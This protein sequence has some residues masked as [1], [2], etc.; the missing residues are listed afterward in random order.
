MRSFTSHLRSQWPQ[1]CLLSLTLSATTEGLAQSPEED[2]EANEAE[3]TPALGRR[4][5]AIRNG[6]L[7][8]RTI[9]LPNDKMSAIGWLDTPN[10]S[11]FC[12]A[13]VISPT[14]IITAEHCFSDPRISSAPEVNFNLQ[15]QDQGQQ[16]KTF[17]FNQSQVMKHP[18][19]L[20]I[21]IIVFPNAPFANLPGVTPIPINRA[22][23]EGDFYD[24]LIDHQITAAGYGST[25]DRNQSGLFFASVR[26]ELI[27]SR[28]IV[29]NGERRQGI[30]PGDSG[31]PLLAPGVD[32]LVSVLAVESKGDPCCVGI[33]QV[34]RL[35]A[36]YEWI[37]QVSGALVSL[38]PARSGWPSVCAGVAQIGT[39]SDNTL[40][41]CTGS[42]V[43][44][45]DCGVQRCDYDRNS[46]QVSCINPCVNIPIE[47][48]CV[49]PN[50][51]ERCER[52][53]PITVQCDAL[54]TCMRLGTPER[55]GWPA[56]INTGPLPELE[57]QPIQAC[58]PNEESEIR[59]ASEARFVGTSSC[60]QSV[61][62]ERALW[63][64]VICAL[65][66]LSRRH[67]RFNL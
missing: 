62:A 65:W 44:Q 12:T 36:T 58:I 10:I 63:F 67:E 53:E 55:P 28:S 56:C 43:S 16:V 30:C 66:G 37:D 22:P 47:G 39:C 31:G 1:L 17:R 26:V 64:W 25:F 29:V 7:V 35:D 41:Q 15:I 24:N 40:F 3:A 42:E 8:P 49:A 2:A 20:D 32:G 50:I 14:A 52:G 51:L 61:G 23:I 45:I 46:Q 5:N 59:E 38:G 18:D 19:Q 34:T 60:R 11:R 21:A 48:R 54:S 13:T 57:N 6:F 27:T 9:Y 4:S 33:D